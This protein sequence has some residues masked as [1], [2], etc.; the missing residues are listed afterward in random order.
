M[1]AAK[2]QNNLQ[3]ILLYKTEYFQPV[4]Q[5]LLTKLI[6]VM[7]AHRITSTLDKIAILGNSHDGII[8]I[9]VREDIPAK[10]INTIPV[11]NFGRLSVYLNS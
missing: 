11:K 3:I 4:I 1:H 6:S 7:K 2:H 5:A 9:F 8:L 10:K